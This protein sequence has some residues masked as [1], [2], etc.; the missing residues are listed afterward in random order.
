M[1]KRIIFIPFFLFILFS[2]K[3]NS[4]G[5]IIKGTITN[6]GNKTL[7][8]D[9]VLL[10][11]IETID[12]LKID[13]K[14]DFKFSGKLN[15]PGIFILRFSN[16]NYLYLIA[17]TT[18]KIVIT[19]D[20]ANLMSSYTVKGSENSKMLKELSIHNLESIRKID[21]LRAIF[22]N[23]EANAKFDSV[24][25]SLD[26]SFNQIFTEE[27]LFL[28]SFINKNKCSFASFMALYQQLGPRNYVFNINNDFKYF[29]LVDSCLLIKYPNSTFINS[30]HTQVTQI[31]N[32]MIA[33]AN[34]K[35][36][37]I[38]DLAT[39]ISLPAPDGNIINLSSLKGKYVLLDFW[40]S[41]CKPCRA[42]NPTLVSNYDKYHSKGFEIYS[43]SL[44]QDKQQW[45]NAI[46]TD[47]LSWIHVSDL[48][49]WNSPV[50]L[51]YNIQA[52]PANLLLDKEGKIIG[53]NLRG[54]ALSSKLAEIFK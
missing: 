54:N 33:K 13:D 52:I 40:A 32:E 41:W 29:D 42:E 7:F 19:A 37:N 51:Q 38:G 36:Y 30:L 4:E 44:D 45:I 15:E 18:D 2:C 28:T 49:F 16:N 14:G 26:L 8:L 48:K 23:N 20:G 3:S 31:K 46:K 50:A 21:S 9:K 1:L 10:N 25:K 35:N 39:E 5:Y 24:K 47:K 22:K 43:V 34:S 12:S 11:K 6:A 17:D 27:K 53:K